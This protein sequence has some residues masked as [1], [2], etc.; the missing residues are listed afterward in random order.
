MVKQ[1]LTFL[2]VIL[3][4]Q[5]AA[6]VKN[7]ALID[8]ANAAP[9]SIEF[10]W[11]SIEQWYQQHTA[12]KAAANNNKAPLVFLGDSITA[13]WQWGQNREIYD[14]A[15]GRYSPLN[16]GVGGDQTQELLWRLKDG[17]LG[18]LVPRLI[19]LMIGTNNIGHSQHSAEEVVRG[20][21]AI[22]GFL[23]THHPQTRLLLL[24]LLPAGQQAD[25]PTRRTILA[26]NRRLATFAKQRNAV[27]VDAGQL[28][29]DGRG[30]ISA[31]L[32][33]DFLH[34]THDGYRKLADFLAPT[35]EQ[36]M[37]DRPTP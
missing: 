29:V 15:F 4:W 11:M 31:D 23:Q 12:N 3:C 25:T 37:S 8:P 22:V 36:L 6:A 21:E 13:G 27:F 26:V 20:I 35:V 17:T 28:F 1:G 19:V 9:R 10:D 32:M 24:G 18:S 30:E 5:V 2:L 14:S 7:T 33:A 34:P 16:F